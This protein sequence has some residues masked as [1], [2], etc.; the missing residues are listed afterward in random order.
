M[1]PFEHIRNFKKWK[2]NMTYNILKEY[3]TLFHTEKIT[4]KELAA[5]I[6]LWQSAT[7]NI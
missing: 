2:L 3:F 7:N 1:N 6:Y 4:K 5:A